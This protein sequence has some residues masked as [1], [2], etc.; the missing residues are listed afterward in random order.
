MAYKRGERWYAEWYGPNEAGRE[1]RY[2]RSLGPDI[3]TR[4]EAEREEHRLAA[5]VVAAVSRRGS[6]PRA[7]FSGLAR[8]WLEL[9]V[10]P[11]LRPSTVK[12]YESICRVWL[13]PHFQHEDLADVVHP[14]RLAK[15]TAELHAEIAAGAIAPKWANEVIGCLS[16]MLRTAA[17]WGYIDAAPKLRKFEARPPAVDWYTAA[18]S[19]RW[20]STCREVRP[21]WWLLFLVGFRTGLRIGE[22]YALRWGDVEIDR[23]RL[24]V[25]RSTTVG[26]T[27]ADG[28]VRRLEATTLPKSGRERIV[29]LPPDA[30]AALAGCVGPADGL[31]F[32]VGRDDAKYPWEAV[33][34]ASGLRDIGL[35]GMRHTFASQLVAAGVSLQRVQVLLGHASIDVTQ[36]YAHLAPSDLVGSTDVLAGTVAGTPASAPANDQPATP[37][38]VVG[39][40]GFEPTTRDHRIR[41]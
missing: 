26:A 36:R 7:A 32:G 37:V 17:E 14:A 3:R 30:L 39:A 38:D 5:E 13:V 20:L 2:R 24:H 1:V 12:L 8:R 40:E 23:R 4:K 15:L 22:L 41:R 10:V 34:K 11:T 35:H 18:E 16:S 27:Y 28:K 19:T 29:P 33:C 25:R 9:V 6:A 31:V 21:G